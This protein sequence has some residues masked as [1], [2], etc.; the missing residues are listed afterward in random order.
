MCLRE[1]HHIAVPLR[2]PAGYAII[3][4]DINL[5][6]RQKLPTCEHKDLQKMLKMVQAAICEILKEESGDLEPYY[7]LGIVHL[8]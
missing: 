3:V 4:F 1:D 5:G 2:D 8:G 7:V 6:Q